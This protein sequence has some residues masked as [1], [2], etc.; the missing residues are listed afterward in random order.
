MKT[1]EAACPSPHEARVVAAA[2]AVCERTVRRY[3]LGKPVRSTCRARINDALARLGLEAP[4]L[5]L[6]E[7]TPSAAPDVERDAPEQGVE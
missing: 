6:S 5:G 3:F 1:Q 7:A 2:A 4:L